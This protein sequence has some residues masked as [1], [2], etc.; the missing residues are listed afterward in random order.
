MSHGKAFF[1]AA[2]L[3]LAAALPLHSVSAP[4][5][6]APQAKTRA[7]PAVEGS[8]QAASAGAQRAKPEKKTVKGYTL[9]PEKYR[10][11][12]EFNR[13][14]ERLYFAGFA[15]GILVY[16]FV[17]RWRLG[18]KYRDWAERVSSRRVVQAFV[19]APLLLLTLRVLNLP[20]SAYSHWL[21]QKFGLSVQGWGSWAWDWVKAQLLTMVFG[22]LLAWILFGVIRRSPRRWWFYFWLA[23]LPIIVFLVFVEPLA[24]EPLFFRFEPLAAKQPELVAQIEKVAQRGGLRIPPDRMFVMKA[25]AK[26]NAVNAYVT[27][28]GASKRVVVWDTTLAKMN[29]PQTLAVFGHEMGH[30]VLRDVPQ[31]I[32]LFSAELFVLLLLGFHAL[33]AALHRW[34]QR[35]AIRGANDWAALPVI[36][37]LFL[38]FA[39]L[40]APVEN[41]YSRY[42]E[43][44]A[45][46]YSLEVIHGIVPDSGEVAAQSFQMMGEI[47]LED[48]HPSRFIRIWL[49]DHPP[50]EDRLV[51]AQTYDPWSKGQATQFVKE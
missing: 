18:P 41:S 1:A 19:C 3:L 15:Y 31:G 39:F 17:L 37:L 42:I 45:D 7:R 27:G 43:H 23:A 28:I 46:V 30:Y 34:G 33:Q 35:W 29:V 11:A 16:L 47:N 26:L 12:V 49:Y 25:S 4:V 24:V 21:V 32:A 22:A 40:A 10:Q 20:R 44:R 2:G 13:A 14:R 48:P 8:P 38:V 51:F 6:V 9:S 50:L 36:L 5:G